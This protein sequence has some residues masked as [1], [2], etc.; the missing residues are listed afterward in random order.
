LRTETKGLDHGVDSAD[1]L[2]RDE[3]S[4][5]PVALFAYN[6][7][8]HLQKTIESLLQNAES[9]S[10]SLYIFSDAPKNAKDKKAVDA[11]RQYIRE[12]KGF[13]DIR[14]IERTE[15]LGLAKS[16]IDGV[17]Q[18]CAEQGRII[19]LEDDMVVSKY[20]LEFM[21]D[22]LRLYEHNDRVISIHGYTYPVSQA[23]PET[24]FLR[25]AHCWGW[26][27]WERGWNCFE[28]NGQQL[29]DELK[30]R[31]LT[32]Q[33]D[34]NGSYPYTKMLQNQI[35]GRNNSWA[36]RWY[37]SAF[38]Q[39]KLTLYAGRNLVRNTGTDGTGTHFSVTRRFSNTIA[40]RPIILDVITTTENV[41]A[42]R[43]IA[44][45]FARTRPSMPVRLAAAMVRKLL[46]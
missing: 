16:I 33:F 45:F 5:A 4:R 12:V 32:K 36:I 39:D 15:N 1:A 17:T 19:V 29:L 8:A 7:Q 22:A 2:M 28:P 46:G 18:V 30:R 35:D 37:A 27:T 13:A 25:A 14:I 23:L 21:N 26:A 38:L 20:F 11:V 31:E 10:S 6:R 3:D 41:E 43:A 44:D 34:F 24:F 40:D 42:K 9:S